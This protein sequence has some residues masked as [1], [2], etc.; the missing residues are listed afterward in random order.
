MEWPQSMGR[1]GS[2]RNS[3]EAGGAMGGAGHASMIQQK[4]RGRKGRWAGESVIVE[5]RYRLRSSDMHEVF[6]P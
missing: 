1:S 6:N 5:E 2:L 4:S 3:R